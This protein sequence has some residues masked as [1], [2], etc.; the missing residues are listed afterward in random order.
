M[1]Q[2]NPTQRQPLVRRRAEQEVGPVLEGFDV[3]V[4]L[5][6]AVEKHQ[7]ASPGSLEA[8]GQVG[9]VGVIG[10]SFTDTGRVTAAQTSRTT[11][12]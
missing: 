7:S 11:S 9:E 1:E 8:M 10:L 12:T 6:E 4:G 5:I 2:G 3:D